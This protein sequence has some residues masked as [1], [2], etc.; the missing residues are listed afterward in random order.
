MEEEFH[1]NFARQ[2]YCFFFLPFPRP[3]SLNRAYLVWFQAQASGQSCPWPFVIKIQITV[4]FTLKLVPCWN[5]YAGSQ[6]LC[7]ET[8]NSPWPSW[9]AHLAFLQLKSSWRKKRQSKLFDSSYE[10][11]NSYNSYPGGVRH[12][13]QRFMGKTVTASFQSWHGRVRIS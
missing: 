7:M 8:Q 12:D 5:F 10:S 4:A 9:I 6:C 13:P 2:L 1:G 11:F 3:P